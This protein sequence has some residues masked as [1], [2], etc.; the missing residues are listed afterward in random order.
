[1]LLPVVRVVA[2]NT[3]RKS[4]RAAEQHDVFVAGQPAEVAEEPAETVRRRRRK[5]QVQTRHRNRKWSWEEQEAGWDLS[6]IST[7]DTFT[8]AAED[9]SHV[10]L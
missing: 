5:H 7:S 3:L 2:S 1:M 10:W 4:Q 8:T 9:D 6:S